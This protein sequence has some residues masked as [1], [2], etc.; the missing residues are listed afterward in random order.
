MNSTTTP[1]QQNRP[2]SS[3]GTQS[4]PIPTAADRP[5]SVTPLPPQPV[6]AVTNDEAT[7]PR[8]INFT[9]DR[10]KDPSL[11]SNQTALYAGLAIV[12]AGLLAV[13]AY[14]NQT[15]RAK[16]SRLTGRYRNV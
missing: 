9:D 12:V 15:V 2:V 11:A 1:R 3:S 7:F 5:P 16:I 14:T 6:I 4:M 8:Y 10:Y 13:S